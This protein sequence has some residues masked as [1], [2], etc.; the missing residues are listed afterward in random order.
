MAR[1]KREVVEE[2]V[3]QS[4]P[5]KPNCCSGFTP[6]QEPVKIEIDVLQL[7]KF[8]EGFPTQLEADQELIDSMVEHGLA[9]K[10]DEGLMRG[11]KWHQY[12]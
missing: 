10:T 3:T 2:P 1:Q 11:H 8:L 4:K 6:P 9:A 12:N 5:V 7:S